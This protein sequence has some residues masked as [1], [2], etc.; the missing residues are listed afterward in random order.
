MS[1]L[2]PGATI[3][4]HSHNRARSIGQGIGWLGGTLASYN[5]WLEEEEEEKEEERQ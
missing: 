1:G 4:P 2:T 3:L 5:G